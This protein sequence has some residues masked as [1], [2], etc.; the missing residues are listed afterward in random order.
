MKSKRHTPDQV[1]KKLAEGDKLLNEFVFRFNRRKSRS[2]GLVFHR[3]LELAV[4]HE[5]VPYRAIVTG[6][7]PRE[8]APIPPTTRG[9]PAS[10]ERPGPQRPWRSA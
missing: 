4:V 2:R 5:P 3:L 6:S 1:I 8:V 9:H 10:L 7:K